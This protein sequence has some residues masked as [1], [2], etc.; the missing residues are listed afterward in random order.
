MTK[1]LLVFLTVC[2]LGSLVQQV[3]AEDLKSAPVPETKDVV[4]AGVKPAVADEK[5]VQ[6]NA[7]K[8]VAVESAKKTDAMPSSWR[9]HHHGDGGSESGGAAGLA[10]RCCKAA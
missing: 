5:K 6:D 8:V 4:S 7:A 1:K 3:A 10:V 9:R 2:W